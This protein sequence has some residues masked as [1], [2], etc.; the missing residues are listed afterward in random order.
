MQNDIK[1]KCLEFL[2]GQV[3]KGNMPQIRKGMVEDL[4]AFVEGLRAAEQA[5]QMAKRFEQISKDAGTTKEV[6]NE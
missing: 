2:Y 5:Q 1:S 4:E 6:G 3:S